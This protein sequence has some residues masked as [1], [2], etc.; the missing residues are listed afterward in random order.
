MSMQRHGMDAKSSGLAISVKPLFNAISYPISG[1]AIDHF[2][3][4]P[5][6]VTNWMNLGLGLIFM[7]WP[8]IL[9]KTNVMQSKM[10]AD[11]TLTK[12]E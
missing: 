3:L 7:A 10:Q 8:V 4:C 2:K 6:N 9:S 11:K 5:A 12:S 1:W